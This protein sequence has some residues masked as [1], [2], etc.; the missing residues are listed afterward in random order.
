MSILGV[1]SGCTRALEL[2]HCSA[3]G[4]TQIPILHFGA[5]WATKQQLCLQ[6]AMP[7]GHPSHPRNPPQAQYLGSWC[8]REAKVAHVTLGRRKGEKRM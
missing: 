8:S 6:S 4:G 3:L 5:T 2:R 7:V 1:V